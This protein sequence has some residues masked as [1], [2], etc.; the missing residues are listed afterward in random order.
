MRTALSY[1]RMIW[2][3]GFIDSGPRNFTIAE[4][5]RRTSESWPLESRSCAVARKVDNGS[6]RPLPSRAMP[7]PPLL[8]RRQLFHVR[9]GA[10]FRMGHDG[11][12]G[13]RSH[14]DRHASLRA[15]TRIHVQRPGGAVHR[16]TIAQAGVRDQPSLRILRVAAVE[17]IW[18]NS[19]HQQ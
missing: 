9:M 6:A 5:V 7:L 4:T 1:Q 13:F 8:K 17:Q 11:G 15:S 19:S 18:S 12:G 3:G 14:S 2:N 10:A 16:Q